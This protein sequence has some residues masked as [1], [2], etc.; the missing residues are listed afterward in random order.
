MHTGQNKLCIITPIQFAVCINSTYAGAHICKLACK[1]GDANCAVCSSKCDL[2]TLAKWC[3]GHQQCWSNMRTRRSDEVSIWHLGRSEQV[4]ELCAPVFGKAVFQAQHVFSR[5][6]CYTNTLYSCQHIY[7]QQCSF[8]DRLQG[9]T[10]V[11]RNGQLFTPIDR[12]EALLSYRPPRPKQRCTVT[13]R[14]NLK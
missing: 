8:L 5:L 2:G 14:L 4:L 1:I 3:F 6:K 11:D 13:L 9:C 10:V 7:T 12:G